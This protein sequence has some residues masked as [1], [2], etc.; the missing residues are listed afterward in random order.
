[1]RGATNR[2]AL[3]IVAG[4][5]TVACAGAG[6]ISGDTAALAVERTCKAGFKPSR[7][8]CI[9]ENSSEVA[10]GF[11]ACDPPFFR[12]LWEDKCIREA[13]ERNVYIHES[14]FLAGM[15]KKRAN[16]GLGDREGSDA[17]CSWHGGL[18]RDESGTICSNGRLVCADGRLSPV[19]TC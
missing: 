12:S 1:M 19:C 15:A 10:T 14:G 7:M 3:L 16:R 6:Q 2:A 4:T 9:P 17:C 13:G 18:A 5:L 8:G 11:W